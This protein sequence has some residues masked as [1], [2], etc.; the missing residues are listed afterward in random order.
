[1]TTLRTLT[2]APAI[3]PPAPASPVEALI[4]KPEVARRL[5]RDVRTIGHWMKAGLIPYY[6]ISR[7]VGF[8]WS[9]VE[10]VLRARYQ[11]NGS[12]LNNN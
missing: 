4:G 9:E 11:V 7:S 6:K 8:K 10:T 1:M 3:R 5:N 12:G 2:P